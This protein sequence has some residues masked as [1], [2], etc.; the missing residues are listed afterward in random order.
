MRVATMAKQA[1][2]LQIKMQHI[3]QYS[4]WDSIHEPYNVV[5]NILKDDESVYKALT[6]DLDLTVAA[7]SL[8]YVSEVI[9]Y[10][11]DCGPA[12][13]EL[14]WSNT[15]DKWTLIKS[16]ACSKAGAQKMTVPGEH[17][18]K[19]LRIR[20]VNNVRGGNLVNVRYV[21]VK[22]LT[23]FNSGGGE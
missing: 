12:T 18:M 22:G 8:A 13:V 6:P 4:K 20:C 21:Q 15:A 1:I 16:F 23:K 10:P 2:P 9:L 7:G 19:Y 3:Y 5:E 17:I 11:G 14:Y